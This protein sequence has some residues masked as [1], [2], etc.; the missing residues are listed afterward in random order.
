MPSLFSSCGSIRRSTVKLNSIL[1]FPISLLLVPE[2]DQDF[3]YGKKLQLTVVLRCSLLYLGLSVCVLCPDY[4]SLRHVGLSI[5][6]FLFIIGIMVISCKWAHFC[7]ACRLCV[8]SCKGN[9]IQ[10]VSHSLPI[11]NCRWQGLPAAQ[12]SQET[13]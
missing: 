7:L 2:W 10:L 13:I 11:P 6:A 5:A 4:E 1:F 3:T 12:V 8:I 9:Y